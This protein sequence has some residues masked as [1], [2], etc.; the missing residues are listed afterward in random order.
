MRKRESK[1]GNEIQRIYR[2]TPDETNK[3]IPTNNVTRR[4]PRTVALCVILFG[5]VALDGLLLYK[6]KRYTEETDRLRAG[7]TSLERARAD[8]IVGAEGDRSELIVQLMRRQAV[9]DDAVHLA[10]NS[11]SAF[12]ALDR[13]GVRLRVIPATMGPARRVGASP[14]TLWISAPKGLRRVDRRVDST[15]TFAFPA[16]VWTDRSLPVPVE[17]SGEGFLSADAIVTT[18][19]TLIYAL[20]RNGPLAD[21]SYVMPGAV[22]VSAADLK[23][24]RDN[25]TSGMRVYFF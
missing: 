25:V 21:S 10:V 4:I 2:G 15:G 17:R 7:M 22:R 6:R 16:W 20:P 13:G 23:A 19:G 14:D 1:R 5:L 3:T 24:I 18:G 11:D 9:G 8:A 12:V